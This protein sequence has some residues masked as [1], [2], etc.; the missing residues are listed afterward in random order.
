DG[1]AG[2]IGIDLASAELQRWLDTNPTRS[3]PDEG[4]EPRAADA[5]DDYEEEPDGSGDRGDDGIPATQTAGE[6][7]SQ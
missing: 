6:A 3:R 5:R 7:R 4:S 2:R 1:R